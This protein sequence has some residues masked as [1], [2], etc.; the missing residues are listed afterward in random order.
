MLDF[1]MP[2][3]YFSLIKFVTYQAADS[4]EQGLIVSPCDNGNC[5][6]GYQNGLAIVFNSNNGVVSVGHHQNKKIVGFGG[7]FDGKKI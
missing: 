5:Y 2:D 3:H 6:F 7:K 1:K 4:H